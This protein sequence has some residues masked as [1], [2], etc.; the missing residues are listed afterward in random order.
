MARLTSSKRA[1]K[2]SEL[3]N[4]AVSRVYI[5]F[6][7]RRWRVLHN[8][9]SGIL[10]SSEEEIGAELAEAKSASMNS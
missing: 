6:R 2:Y 5:A 10:E 4:E 8:N 9:R 7:S 3:R 1:K